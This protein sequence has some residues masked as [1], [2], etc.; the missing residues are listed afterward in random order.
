MSDHCLKE[1]AKLQ[2]LQ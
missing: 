1:T 2:V